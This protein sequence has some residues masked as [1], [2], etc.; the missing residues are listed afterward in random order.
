MPLPSQEGT[1]RLHRCP[2]CWQV[3]DTSEDAPHST[4]TCDGWD[5]NPHETERMLPEAYRY[6][7]PTAD[8][9]QGLWTG[10]NL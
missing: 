6:L 4:Y 8:T 10:H 2:V 3:R 5:D 9:D 7:G 1:V